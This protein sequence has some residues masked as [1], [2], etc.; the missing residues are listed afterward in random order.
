MFNFNGITHLIENPKG[1]APGY[2][3]SFVGAVPVG[4]LEPR[5]P[6]MSDIM[7]GRVQKDGYAYHGRKL[8]TVEQALLVAREGGAK[9]CTSPGCACRELF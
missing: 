5:K 3:F 7:G 6:T 1:H 9:L 4:C 8:E 2:N